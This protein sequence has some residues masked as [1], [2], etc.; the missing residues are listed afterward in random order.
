MNVQE[1]NSPVVSSDQAQ[2]PIPPFALRSDAQCNTAPPTVSSHVCGAWPT[3]YLKL[4]LQK[5]EMHS[6][7]KLKDA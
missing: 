1:K 2:H 5:Q 3:L 7:Y 4:N 6:A